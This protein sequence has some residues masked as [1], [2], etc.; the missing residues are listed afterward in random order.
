MNMSNKTVFPYIPNSVPEIQEEMLK[1][2]G[3]SDVMELYEEIPEELRVK[4]LLNLPTPIRDEL[5]IK[6]HME[7]ILSQN[8]NCNEYDNFMGAGCAMHYVPSVCDEIAGRGELLTCYGAETWADHG[9]YQIFF[10]YQSMMAELLEMDFLTVPCHCGGQ[11]VS[12]A[13]CMANRITGRKKILV[14]KTMTPQNLLIAENYV[15]SVGEEN[16][17]VIEKVNYDEKTGELDI[18]DLK[19][20][21]NEDTA[22]VLIE[23]PNYLG[24]IESQGEV[25]GKL[26]REAGAE[27]IVYADPISLGV[28]EAPAVYGATI[29]VG[30]L[31]GLGLHLQCGGAQAGYIACKD[32]MK[33]MMEFKELVDGI[34]ETT[35]PGEIGYTVVLMERTHYAMREK[36]REFTGTQNNLW[37]APVAVYLSLMGPQGMWEIGDTIMTKSQYAAMRFAE[38]P[39][40]KVKFS[41]AFFKEFVLDYNETNKTVKEIEECLLEDKIF[42]GVS[43]KEDFPE[44]G[45]CALICVTEM[46]TKEAIDHMA[47]SLL[48]VVCR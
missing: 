41:S 44:L 11:A 18:D 21:L 26:A 42:A 32:D 17:L 23:N 10:E 12:T 47:E 29:C 48:K 43:L 39:G 40:V 4:G 33:Y 5:G 15:R 25:I 30:D 20:K 6:R 46:V 34:V 9:K 35:V 14:P 31:H 27:F 22:A 36:G 2:V 24:V 3:A 8:K 28:I 45:E 37:T 38:I 1:E 13:F 19:E 7:R 16:S